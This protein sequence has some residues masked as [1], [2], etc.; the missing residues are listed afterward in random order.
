MNRHIGKFA[1]LHVNDEHCRFWEE[2]CV[3]SSARAVCGLHENRVL[4]FFLSNRHCSRA[5][6]R[7]HPGNTATGARR[8]FAFRVFFFFLTLFS[9]FFSV[10]RR[11]GRRTD[12][13]EEK[14]IR[15]KDVAAYILSS[16]KAFV[17]IYEHPPPT[18]RVPHSLTPLRVAVADGFIPS[19]ELCDQRRRLDLQPTPIKNAQKK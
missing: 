3:P 19:K 7:C 9:A 12:K 16:A 15:P 14:K 8:V 13:K 4:F 6:R 1:R 10:R 5:F 2:P 11:P 18:Q 17:L